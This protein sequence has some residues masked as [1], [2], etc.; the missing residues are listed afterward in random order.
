LATVGRVEGQRQLQESR[1]GQREAWQQLKNG[2]SRHLDTGHL[3]L[4]L[5]GRAPFLSSDA[6]EQLA[7]KR[8]ALWKHNPAMKYLNLTVPVEP[9][10]K[11]P[12]RHI[13]TCIPAIRL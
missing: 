5:I 11:P 3:F 10:N 2:A 1:R 6:K 4:D 12:R 7:V 9:A 8:V 13:C